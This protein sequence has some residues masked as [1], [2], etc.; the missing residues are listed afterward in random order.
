MVCANP[1]LVVIQQG[2]RSICA[3]AVAERYEALGGRVRWHGKPF[4]SVYHTCFGLLGIAEKSR[5]LAV[6]DSLRTD[7]AG[8]AG[9]GIDSLL[10]TGGIHA[11]EFGV[12]VGEQ[13]DVGQLVAAIAAAGHRPSA[14]IAQF[15]W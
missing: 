5:I 10:V 4:A 1:D 6:G 7:I 11:E 13:P 12:A 3:G 14:V 15:R 8:A 9:A 2:H